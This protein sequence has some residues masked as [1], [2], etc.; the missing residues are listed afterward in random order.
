MAAKDEQQPLHILFFPFLAPGH[1]I[2]VADMAA[3]FAA[4][5]VKCTILTTPVNAAIIRSAVDRTNDASRGTDAPAIDISLFPFPDVGLPQGVESVDNL[6][7]EADTHTFLK[8][9]QWLRE[10]FDRFL[11]EH[12]PD[13]VV[14]DSF[15]EWSAEAAAEHGVPRLA[16]LGSS[17]F[18]RACTDCMLRN[19]PVK[20]SPDD[21]D[22][23][24]SL[25][26]LPHRVAMRRSQMIDPMKQ[27]DHWAFYQ[28]ANAADQMSY[29]EVFNSF[30]EL[31]PDYVE[32]YHTTLGRRVWL[33]GPVAFA[34]KDMASRGTS[35]L[36]PDADSC[37]RWLDEKAAGS[38][39][40][41]SFGTLTRFSTAELREIA[42]GLKLSGKN[43]VWVISRADTDTSQWM[44][45]GFA[46]LMARGES[47]L[48]IRGWAPQVLIL[49]HPAVG[50]FVTH[51]GWNSMLE[52]M[53][54]GMPLVTWP[55]YADQFFNEKLIVEQLKVGVGVGA[56]D[57][58][59]F[60]EVRRQVISGEVIAEA[61]GRVMGDGEEGEAI[62][63]KAKELG[64]KARR[65]VEKGGSSYG[66]V[67]RLMNELMARRSSVNVSVGAGRGG[68]NGGSG[69]G[70]AHG[71]VIST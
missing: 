46:E 19:N 53:S 25:P 37:L 42:R 14:A 13:A 63:K 60:L 55:G 23:V 54:A 52:A 27:Q 5:G 58:A 12:H 69:R 40:Y 7:S 11:A 65:A 38:V 41:V 71:G 29:G 32:H 8:A 33:F 4:R 30:H 15:F 2:P 64:Q 66:D 61:I 48:I 35:G 26:G 24:V 51:C 31:E 56:S 16:F 10:P 3:L 47:G 17:L 67:G 36:S 9:L 57:Y 62:R 34:S 18:A 39:V 59:S 44:P 50:G 21:P 70:Q 20:S 28:R 22:T 45:E 6:W 49:N 68:E 43:F 1:L